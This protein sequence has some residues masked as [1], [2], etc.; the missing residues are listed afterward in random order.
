[1]NRQFTL[2]ASPAAHAAIA[3]M[4]QTCHS[5]PVLRAGGC[6]TFNEAAGDRETRR[7]ALAVL[8]Q[9]VAVNPN[10]AACSDLAHLKR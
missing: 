9:Q 4:P 2:S 6:R 8:D 3:L 5:C 1:M 7:E 10:Q